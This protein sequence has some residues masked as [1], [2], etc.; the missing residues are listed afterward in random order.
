MIDELIE[1]LQILSR[2]DPVVEATVDEIVV[3]PGDEVSEDHCVKLI[4]LGWTDHRGDWS[5]LV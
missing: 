4:M 1:G 5:F 2:Y 3:N